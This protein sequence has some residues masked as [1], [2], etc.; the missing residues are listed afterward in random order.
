MPHPT[1]SRA[2]RSASVRRAAA[3]VAVKAAQKQNKTPDPKMVKLA[4]TK[5]H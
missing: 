2:V 3:K 4:A 5:V 1:R